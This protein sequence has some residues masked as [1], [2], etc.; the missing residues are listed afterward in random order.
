MWGGGP[1][2]ITRPKV[3]GRSPPQKNVGG[4]VPHV[5]PGRYAHV[6]LEPTKWYSILHWYLTMPG[7]FDKKDLLF[8]KSMFSWSCFN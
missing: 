1:P 3:G 2:H 5:P 4:R 6:L 8:T 7:I